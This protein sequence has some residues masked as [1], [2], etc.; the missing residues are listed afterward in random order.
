MTYVVSD[1]HG[2][3]DKFKTLLEKISF[4]DSDVM[5]VLG[6]IVDYG[7]ESIALIED[8][9]MRS[10]VLPIV[11]DHDYRA[12]KL[13]YSLDTMLREGD[14]PDS[15]TLALMTEWISE[16]GQKT[17]QDFKELDEDRREGVLD[18]LSDMALYE[19]IEVKGQKYL[20]VHAGIA[21]FDPSLDLDDCMPEDFINEPLDLSREYYDDK[22]II[23]GH[24][25]T[26][27]VD[28]ADKGMV[29]YGE[30]SML[31]DCGAAFGEVLGC[32]CLESGK[33]YYV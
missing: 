18:Y 33:E 12:L 25:P 26:Y 3:Y 5:Y 4:S 28:G 1:I 19:E 21:D 22:I 11:G 31:I 15:E 23:A 16:G 20:L 7:E 2:N 27:N 17:M 9:S 29:F 13:L 14:M 32:V 30:G 6:D 8:L 24:V 10:N